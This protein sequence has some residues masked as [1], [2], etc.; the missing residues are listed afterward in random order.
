MGLF[1]HQTTT[2]MSSKWLDGG[3]LW[4]FSY[5]KPQ[6]LLRCCDRSCVVYGSFPTSNHNLSIWWTRGRCVVYG[7][8]PTSNHN[9]APLLKILPRGC[10]WVFSYIKPQPSD[11]CV[12]EAISCL[13]VFSYIKPQLGK[14]SVI[15]L[16]G[17]LWVF[18]YIKPQRHCLNVGDLGV[19]YGSFPTSNHNH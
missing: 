13:W 6:P 1:L 11:S 12:G 8:F 4:V 15:V 16:Y 7:S 5:I 2:R 17:C 3:C 14:H 9:F 10:L 19:V 18:S